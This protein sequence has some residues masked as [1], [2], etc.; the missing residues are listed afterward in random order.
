LP[1]TDLREGAI[2][3][4][5]QRPSLPKNFH[6]N[7]N[8]AILRGEAFVS[9]SRCACGSND[10]PALELTRRSGTFAPKLVDTPLVGI[11]AGPD[12]EA[13][14]EDGEC[15]VV[16]SL[17]VDQRESKR[18]N[19]ATKIG[20]DSSANRIHGTYGSAVAARPSRGRTHYLDVDWPLASDHH[21]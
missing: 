5:T 10:P 1:F 15:G 8:I 20:N 4:N 3:L 6:G 9:I 11:R 17:S 14:Q 7:Y 13:L 12:G 21:Y 19:S 2:V 18:W 16:V